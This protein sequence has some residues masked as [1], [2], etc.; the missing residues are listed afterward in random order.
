MPIQLL[1]IENNGMG[2]A[3]KYSINQ[4]TNSGL[5]FLRR[6]LRLQKTEL[7]LQSGQIISQCSYFFASCK[8]VIE[9]PHAYLPL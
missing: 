7:H 5:Y 3:M 6:L 8:Q 4:G 1:P 9:L 2:I